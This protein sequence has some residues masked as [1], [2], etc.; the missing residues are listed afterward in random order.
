MIDNE[1][2]IH[3]YSFLVNFITNYGFPIFVSICVIY[4]LYYIWKWI[5]IEIKPKLSTVISELTDVTE[6]IKN[7]EHDIEKLNQKVTVITI[8]KSQVNE[9]PSEEIAEYIN[10]HE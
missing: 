9:R 4:V 7:L 5:T 8:L 6:K 1:E 2:N 3:S 10:K